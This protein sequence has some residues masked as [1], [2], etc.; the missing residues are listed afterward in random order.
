M[1][2]SARRAERLRRAC[3][4]KATQTPPALILVEID[5]DDLLNASLSELKKSDWWEFPETV[6]VKKRKTPL[7]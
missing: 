7:R 6:V 3:Q 1:N 2:T 5:Q 4:A